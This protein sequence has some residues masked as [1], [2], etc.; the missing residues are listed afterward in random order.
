MNFVL[1]RPRVIPTQTLTTQVYPP[2]S[3]RTNI[4]PR[5]YTTI[6][7]LRNYYSPDVVSI[8]QKLDVFNKQSGAQLRYVPHS[9]PRRHGRGTRH[10]PTLPDHIASTQADTSAAK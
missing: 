7:S 4:A 3:V 6:T 5:R 10:P 9:I 8:R 1:T 2:M